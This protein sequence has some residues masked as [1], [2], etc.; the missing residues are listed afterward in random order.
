MPMKQPNQATDR[1]LWKPLVLGC[2]G[3]ALGGLFLFLAGRNVSMSDLQA[4][5]GRTDASWLFAGVVVY[6]TSIGLRC[7]RWG[8]LLRA[9]GSV[10]WRHAAEA[11][12]TGF[13]ANY[14]LPARLGELF[15]ADYARRVF[16]MSRFTALGTIV[17]ERVCDGVILVVALWASFATLL[18]TRLPSA[19]APWVLAVGMMSATVF[20]AAL[21]L[22]LVSQRIELRRFGIIEGVAERW[23]RLVVGISSVLRGRTVTIALCSVAIWS[24][25]AVALGS[26]VRGFGINFSIAE[27]AML[28][29]LASLS[30]L[31]PT[32]PGYIGTYQLVFGHVFGIFGYSEAIGFIAA[33]A[34]QIFCFGTVTILGGL[35]LLSRSG[36]TMWRAHKW[37][38]R[39]KSVL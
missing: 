10:K 3:I 13:A 18:A 27:A 4:A 36:V 21:I 33:I 25:E 8:I 22:I 20:G 15:R 16:N 9:T 26:I 11:L 6:L 28:L 2:A 38:Y 34:V 24:M 23:D 17:A 29:G 31:V 14:V 35:V 30:T 32:A 39:T 12:I 1:R 19:E 7:L 37:A 5:L